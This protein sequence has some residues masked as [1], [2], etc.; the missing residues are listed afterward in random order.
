MGFQPPAPERAGEFAP[1]VGGSV[2]GLDKK[3]GSGLAVELAHHI[4]EAEHRLARA[5]RQELE[6]F[7]R[8][9]LWVEPGGAADRR[10]RTA[11]DD[12]VAVDAGGTVR[13][14]DQPPLAIGVVTWMPTELRT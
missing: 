2:A 9:Q 1:S 10:F 14:R 3:R 8:R 11:L 4:V 6:G 7:L 13:L 5:S 12:L